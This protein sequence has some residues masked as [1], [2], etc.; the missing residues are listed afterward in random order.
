MTGT[1]KE[2]TVCMTRRPKEA[3]PQLVISES[4]LYHYNDPFQCVS[5][6]SLIA[7]SW[8]FCQNFTSVILLDF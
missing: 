1:N 5:L 7:I 3:F 2:N 8:L 6:F 4:F